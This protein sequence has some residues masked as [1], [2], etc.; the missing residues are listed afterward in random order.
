MMR[1]FDYLIVDSLGGSP[2]YESVVTDKPILLYAGIE[3]IVWDDKFV[4]KL[5]HR[6]I[7]FFDET[8]YIQGL[9]EFVADPE[10]YVQKSRIKRTDDLVQTYMPPVSS[11]SFWS[12]VYQ[13][14][15]GNGR[16][17]AEKS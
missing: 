8:T 12:S 4:E 14:F 15:W 11:E 1:D 9:R 10:K 13:A 17:K 5:K 3:N 6:V 2:I 7:C 16:Q